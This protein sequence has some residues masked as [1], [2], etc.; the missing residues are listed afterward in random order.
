MG[1]WMLRGLRAP[2]VWMVATTASL[3]A[4][5]ILDVVEPDRR[6]EGAF[7]VLFRAGEAEG[8]PWETFGEVRGVA[9]DAEGR[10]HVFDPLEARVVVF[11]PDGRYRHTVGG[12]R[13]EGPGELRAPMSFVVL[14]AGEVVLQDAGHQAYVVFDGE[15]RYLRSIPFAMAGAVRAVSISTGG[16]IPDLRGGGFFDG[17]T[18]VSGL[19]VGGGGEGREIRRVPLSDDGRDPVSFRAWR[20][21]GGTGTRAE[22]RADGV[23]AVRFGGGPRIWEPG[24]HLAPLPDGGVALVDSTTWTIRLMDPSG[25][26]RATV[27]RPGL[28]P[29]PVTPRLEERERERRLRLL[30]EEGGGPRITLGNGATLP[31]EQLEALARSRIESA[32]FYP[33]I[34]VIRRLRASPEGLLWVERT[35][36]PGDEPA[37]VDL[38]G[39][40]GRYLGTLVDPRGLPDAVGPGGLV[41]WVERDELD[42]PRVVV[43]RLPERLRG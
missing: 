17:G 31:P 8:E 36:S 10:L 40:D 32:T 12:R 19:G 2:M 39:W 15:G 27:R 34:P 42:V 35:P 7:E 4:Q 21:T 3:G 23:T 38:V 43:A 30:E 9:F 1:S 6:V 20:P 37:P 22:T 18:T 28:E 26:G 5:E 13:G 14:P 24:V 41:A 25:R 11:E 16:L 33:E 29:V